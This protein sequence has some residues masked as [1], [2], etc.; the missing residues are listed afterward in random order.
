MMER[1][2]GRE[3]SG[4][5]IIKYY[6][7]VNKRIYRIGGEASYKL[8]WVHSRT[9]SENP[10]YIPIGFPTRE[11]FFVTLACIDEFILEQRK[12]DTRKKE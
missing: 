9:R 12:K 8:P 4:Y 5:K 2:G 1:E 10:N 11:L 3:K 7:L 6:N